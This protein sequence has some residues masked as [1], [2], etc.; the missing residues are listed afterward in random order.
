MKKTVVQKSRWTIPGDH[1]HID[2]HY[3][4]IL[5][6]QEQGYRTE[7]PDSILINLCGESSPDFST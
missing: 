4:N 2:Q 7:P 6:R 3:S 5:A 1:D